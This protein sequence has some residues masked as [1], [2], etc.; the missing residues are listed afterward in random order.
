MNRE[1]ITI[2]WPN[3]N[4][5]LKDMMHEMLKSTELTDVTL[6]CD[7]KKQLKAHK[8]FLSA[9]SSV[10]KNIFNDLSQ[11][12]SVVYL[13]GFQHQEIES[14]LEFMYF[15]ST[16]FHQER[17]NEFVS[18]AKNFEIKEISYGVKFSAGN[19]DNVSKI[20]ENHSKSLTK[21]INILPK[22][23]KTE[24]PTLKKITNDEQHM[25]GNDVNED[26]AEFL[27]CDQCESQ[28][29]GKGNLENHI[30]SRHEIPESI[31]NYKCNKCEYQ[32]KARKKF[33][34]HLMQS[35]HD[36]IIHSCDQCQK[37]YRRVEDLREHIQ[38]IHEG[39]RYAC[40]FCDHKATYKNSL[41][42]H[43]T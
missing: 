13:I 15:G 5:S 9:C 31:R 14:I 18:V 26:I 23:S 3:H 12:D 11:N 37:T 16:T 38:S 21:M 42:Q 28:F 29:E 20:S 35:K 7:N 39:L 24:N 34:R 33:E 19:V 27:N 36:K 10:F 2:E 8:F 30:Q 32:T 43:N 6:V 41:K 17:L 4:D 25:P 40:N 1:K 22:D